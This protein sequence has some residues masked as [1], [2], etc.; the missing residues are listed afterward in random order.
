M[1]CLLQSF[2]S[3]HQK[4]NPVSPHFVCTCKTLMLSS[5]QLKY[6]QLHGDVACSSAETIGPWLPKSIPDHR[7]ITEWS[8]C[9]TEG[10]VC[11]VTAETSGTQALAQ[12]Q[13]FSFTGNLSWVKDVLKTPRL[14]LHY[15]LI[16]SSVRIWFSLLPV[17]TRWLRQSR[18]VQSG[19]IQHALDTGKEGS[20]GE[21][22]QKAVSALTTSLAL[23]KQRIVRCTPHAKA[24][25]SPCRG[26]CTLGTTDLK[27]QG[28]W[29]HVDYRACEGHFCTPACSLPHCVGV[30]LKQVY[31][32]RSL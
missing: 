26:C 23:P 1:L 15:S 11:S 4:A 3:C 25:V 24:S 13:T 22:Y 19:R 27:Q 17:F 32:L 21:A 18:D 6:L 5:C 7:V 12:G 30:Y 8:D 10:M 9:Q 31:C 16:A 20:L 28:Q 2:T 14:P 29:K